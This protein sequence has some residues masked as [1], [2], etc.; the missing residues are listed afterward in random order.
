MISMKC[1]KK[2]VMLKE[3]AEYAGDREDRILGEI[4]KDWVHTEYMEDIISRFPCR[5]AFRRNCCCKQRKQ[6]E[7]GKNHSASGKGADR[8]DQRGL[9]K[10]PGAGG[11]GVQFAGG[12]PRGGSLRQNPEKGAGEKSRQGE[13]GGCW[14]R[15]PRRGCRPW[16]FPMRT[17][18]FTKP[19]CGDL[20]CGRGSSRST[21][22][23]PG[24]PGDDSLSQ[25]AGGYL[26]VADAGVR[27]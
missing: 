7:A 2:V 8:A 6:S 9:C 26:A 19:M 15:R 21:G 12:E 1:K 11:M 20:P 24:R 27:I 3:E 23:L 10:R 25:R 22:D 14:P 13:Y 5:E 16:I 17:V 18:C 4:R